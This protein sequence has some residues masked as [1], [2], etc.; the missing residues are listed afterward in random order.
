MG[1]TTGYAILCMLS[2]KIATTE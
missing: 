1:E 2:M